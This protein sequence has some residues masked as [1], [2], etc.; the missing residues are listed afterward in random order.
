MALTVLFVSGPR[1]SGKSTVIQ[2]II[3]CCAAHRPHYLRLAAVKG[4]KQPIEKSGAQDDCGVA[5]ARWVRYEKDRAFEVLPH[6]LGRVYATDRHGLVI[7][8]S[9]ADP[10][11]R[12]AYPYDHRIFVMPAPRRHSEVFRTKSQ[13]TEAF[14]AVLNDTAAF[15]QNIFGLID[16]NKELDDGASESRSE[17]TAEEL[18]GLI[19]SPLGDE[20]ATRIL[21]QPTH[22][23]LLEADILV[24]NTAVGGPADVAGDCLRRLRR[25]LNHLRSPTGRRPFLCACDP[26]SS[27]DPAREQ[28]YTRVAELL[29][30]IDDREGEESAP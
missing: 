4:D 15:A 20:L 16:D 13:A 12:S 18:L 26:A 24:V 7:I 17:L 6:T 5:S 8:E 19:R 14:R 27:Q 3:R 23:G 2:Q 25:V 21:L 30:F 1:R 10:V 9:D 11:L 22:H 28:L 29:E